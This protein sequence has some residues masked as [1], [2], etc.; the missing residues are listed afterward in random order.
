MKDSWSPVIGLFGDDGQNMETTIQK[1]GDNCRRK[2]KLLRRSL[3]FRLLGDA[4]LPLV[5][6][7]MCFRGLYGSLGARHYHPQNASVDTQ[8]VKEF[9]K[10]AAFKIKRSGDGS[11]K[12]LL[13]GGVTRP[14]SGWP[15]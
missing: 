10:I 4:S 7:G 8:H 2:W 5:A 15:A 11:G 3:G 6:H 1:F 14:N 12:Q 9:P 13:N